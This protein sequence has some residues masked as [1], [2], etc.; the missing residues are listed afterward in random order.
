MAR[1]G[2]RPIE[3]VPTG[4]ALGAEIRG[5]DLA[6]VDDAAFDLIERAWLEHLVLLFR[7]QRITDDEHLAFSRCFGALE[8]APLNKQGKPWDPDRPELVVLSNLSQD[9]V[10]L[11]ALGNG[12]AIWHTDMSYLE[13]PPTAAIL[14]ALEIP[15]DGS[16]DTWFANM[17]LAYEA[18]DPAMKARIAMSRVIHDASINS[19]GEQRK[20]M[21]VVTDPRQAPG[22]HHPMVRVHPRTG[23]RA[24]YL[25]RRRNAYVLGL[26]LAESEALLDALWAHCGQRRFVWIQ[27]WRVGDVLIW[28]NRC[29]IHRRDGF[30]SA[31]RR[32][33]HRTQIKGDAVIAG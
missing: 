20:G 15:A 18:L 25:G 4:A 2:G 19:G 10:P 27:K 22:A 1:M 29:T 17:Y 8:K 5:I 3:V 14:H 33:V 7:D 12:E 23:R 31:L 21:P 30:D 26:D 9:G 6:Q 16:G 32:R 28:D 13:T 24:L 11:G